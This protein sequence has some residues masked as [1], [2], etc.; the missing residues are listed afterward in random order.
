MNSTQTRLAQNLDCIGRGKLHESQLQGIVRKVKE[1]G[2]LWQEPPQC[3]GR[4]IVIAGGGK[5]AKHAW[6]VASRCRELGW[7]EGIQVWHLGPHEF[8]AE[9]HPL[10]A[11]ID[12][13]LVDAHE[14]RRWHPMR[15]M[16]GWEVKV[17]IAMRCPWRNV[18]YFDADCVPDLNPAEIFN[19]QDVQKVGSLFFSDCFNQHKTSWA[20]TFCGL[21]KLKKEW[22]SG[23]FVVDKQKAWMG[24]R[25]VFW[26][27][28]RADLWYKFGHGDKLCWELGMRIAEVPHLFSEDS[29]WE[30]WG[31]GQYWKNKRFFSHFMGAKRGDHPLPESVQ[32]HFDLWDELLSP[33]SVPVPTDPMPAVAVPA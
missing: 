20:Y 2:L 5:Y 14:V 10:F 27:C 15:M 19:H 3:E 32:P 17:Q 9:Q 23:Q 25:W 6:A 7:Q 16:G 13:E 1:Q 21:K 26:M 18:I 30:G 24:L 22:E 29:R 33:S 8:T 4:G 28:E 12:V 11:Q 31:I